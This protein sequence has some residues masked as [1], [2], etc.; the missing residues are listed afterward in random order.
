VKNIEEKIKSEL[1]ELRPMLQADGGDVEYE[2]FRE[3]VVR[4]R[5]KGACSGCPSAGATLKYGIEKRLK[6]KIPEVKSVE[7]VKGEGHSHDDHERGAGNP[8][9]SRK[10]IDGVKSIIAV[11][12][13]KGGVGKSTVAVNLAA[14]LAKSGAR[15]GLLD[16]DVFGPSIPTML[17]V[18]ERPAVENDTHLVPIKKH[19]ISLMSIGFMI[20]ED[21]PVIWRGPMVMKLIKEF[22]ENVKWGELDYLIVD[23]PPGTGDVQLTLVQSVHISGAIIVTTP[24]NVALIDA[25]R[26]LKMFEKTG[27]PVLGI[28]ENM[29]HFVCPHCSRETDIFSRGGGRAV[30]DKLGVPFLGE[31]PIHAEVRASG[32]RGVPIVLA[33]PES[34]EAMAFAD[35]A[36]RVK[37]VRKGDER[38]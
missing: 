3:G 30:A 17:G 35:I 14:A 32:D 24:S 34:K 4:V 2:G 8:F 6:E 11:A 33:A 28:V 20:E 5:L 27:V 15:V 22:L 29:S 18:H 31:I 23:L 12:S 37:D 25:R 9:E 38:A 16:A 1:E 13:G 26:G 10:P 19:G 7:G 36:R 21:A